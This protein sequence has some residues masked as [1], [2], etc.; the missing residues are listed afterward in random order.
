MVFKP[1]GKMGGEGVVVW[2]GADEDER[3][4]ALAALRARPE[5]MIAQQRVELSAPPHGH[6]GGGSQ[7]RRVDL[8]PY[9]IRSPDGEWAMP[10]GLTRVALE[11]GSLIVNSG[12][13]GG[14]KDTWVL[15]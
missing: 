4:D 8:R 2:S 15:A 7:P 9:L 14:V 5:R 10:E 13:G 11:E 3:A 6:L 1:R 12:R